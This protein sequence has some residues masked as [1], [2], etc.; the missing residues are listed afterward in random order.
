MAKTSYEFRGGRYRG[1][2]AQAVGESLDAIRNSLGGEVTP[3]AVVEYAA[4]EESPLHEA[5]T[6]DDDEAARKHRLLEARWLLRR[7]VVVRKGRDPEP[8]FTSIRIKVE[9][10]RT[11]SGTRTVNVYRSPDQLRSRPRE[12]ALAIQQS[13]ERLDSLRRSVEELERIAGES[14]DAMATLAV[15]MRSLD[16]VGEA[17]AKI[18]SVAV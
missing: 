5:F 1:L 12:L 2:D 17:L 15:A 7:V 6:W 9:D 13:S 16:M 18:H 14:P 8:A 3:S 4:D 11:T 10:A